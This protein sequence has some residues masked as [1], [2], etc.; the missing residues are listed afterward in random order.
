MP[1]L[2][3]LPSNLQFEEA[4]KQMQKMPDVDFHLLIVRTDEVPQLRCQD[5]THARRL[6]QTLAV[7]ILAERI[8]VEQAEGAEA[9]QSL[10]KYP[11]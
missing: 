5:R 6:A 1:K 10:F 4:Y 11:D 2:D 7:A 8:R 9:N 3:S